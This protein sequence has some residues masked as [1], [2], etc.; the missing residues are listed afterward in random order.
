M[1]VLEG[2]LNDPTPNGCNTAII[3]FRKPN[4]QLNVTCFEHD[5]IWSNNR[6]RNFTWPVPT[7]TTE[8][9]KIRR[10][11]RGADN[12]QVWTPW[13]WTPSTFRV[14]YS[15]RSKNKQELVTA[16]IGKSRKSVKKR[17]LDFHLQ[18]SSTM[19]TC[20]INLGFIGQNSTRF[21]Q[22]WTVYNSGT[23]A[24]ASML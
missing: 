8:V 12:L 16:N 6:I 22:E 20:E 13:R 1:Q 15:K 24:V 9:R 3:D 18:N 14:E 19:C 23:N 5:P 21:L 2:F 17:T 4:C 11:R 7:W 10:L